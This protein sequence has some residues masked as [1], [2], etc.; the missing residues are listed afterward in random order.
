M[1]PLEPTL[2]VL[3]QE[4]EDAHS[5]EEILRGRELDPDTKYTKFAAW[6][7][8]EFGGWHSQATG[9]LRRASDERRIRDLDPA[10]RHVDRRPSLG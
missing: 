2:E 7:L 4:F 5:W 8:L 3:I 10:R 9:A 6:T 1:H